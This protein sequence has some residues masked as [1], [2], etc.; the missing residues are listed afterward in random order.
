MP[1]DGRCYNHIDY[2]EVLGKGVA[3]GMATL[4]INK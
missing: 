4:K 3:D 2:W 1:R